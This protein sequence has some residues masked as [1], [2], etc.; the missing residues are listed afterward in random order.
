MQE[1]RVLESYRWRLQCGDG[2]RAGDA[3]VGAFLVTWVRT[4]DLSWSAAVGSA[5]ASFVVEKVGPSNFGTSKQVEK[6]AKSIFER[7]VRLHE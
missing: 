2:D 7:T 5:M 1:A 3:L 4:D 6:R